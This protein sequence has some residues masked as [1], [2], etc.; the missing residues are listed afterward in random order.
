MPIKLGSFDVV[1]G[2]DWISKYHDRI[3]YDEKVLH[4]PINGETLII[5]GN[6]YSL[7]DKN[8]AKTNKTEHGMERAGKSQGQ[9]QK[10]NPEKSKS[11]P[12]PNPKKS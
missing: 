3:I 9:N 1:I 10:I 5:R 6:G 11:K 12:K 4:I 2:M 7:K 8:E